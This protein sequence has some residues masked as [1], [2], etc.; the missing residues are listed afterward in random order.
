MGRTRFLNRTHYWREI[1]RRVPKANQVLAAVAY[2][3][4]GGSDF[5]PL[6]KGDQLVVDLSERAVKQ[7]VSDPREIKRL[8]KRGGRVFTRAWL[9]AKVVVI[10]NVVLTTSANVSHNARQLLEEAAV[11]T[12]SPTAVQAAKN[13]ITRMCSEPVSER[14]LKEI[15]SLYRPPTFKAARTVR[16]PKKITRTSKRARLWYISGLTYIDPKRDS[17]QIM[18]LEQETEKEL[19]DPEHNEVGWIRLGHRPR[20]LSEIQRNNWVVTCTRA[21]KRSYD[22]DPPARVIRKRKYTNKAGKTYHMVMLDRPAEGVV[23]TLTEFRKRWR[24]VAQNGE[25]APKR[26]RPIADEDL[27][28]S[29]LR[30]WTARGKISGRYRNRP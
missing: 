15:I 6:R 5:L 3:G 21:N 8:L 25:Q 14:Y 26:T 13:F 30:F 10:D 16:R 19:I 18:S 28:D 24:H 7:G 4:S 1:E 23:M 17:D 11:L 20:W 27:A 29:I 2:F 12:D 22:L 9:H